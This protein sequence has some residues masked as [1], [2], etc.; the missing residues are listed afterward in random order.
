MDIVSE[1]ILMKL[2]SIFKQESFDI[3]V[4]DD[5]ENKIYKIFIKDIDTTIQTEP[6]VELEFFSNKIYISNINKC[7]ENSGSSLLHLIDNLALSMPNIDYIELNDGSLIE[8]CSTKFFIQLDIFKILTKGISW[9]NSLGYYS[10][11]HEQEV[12]NN[13]IIRTTPINQ[14]LYWCLSYRVNEFLK[15]VSRAELEKSLEKTIAQAK[16]YPD[17]AL[18]NR[19]ILIY[20]Q[21]LQNYD[22]YVEETIGQLKLE[23]DNIIGFG[24]YL[25]PGV[26]MS[27]PT[28][29][30]VN[31]VYSSINKFD[32]TS[33]AN[34]LK[35]RYLRELVLYIKPLITYNINLKKQ[36][37]RRPNIRVGG[38]IKRTKYKRYK[39]LKKN[40]TNKKPK[41]KTKQNKRKENS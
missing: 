18:L 35:Y 27:I 1:D 6:C 40:K 14:L 9:Y 22:K 25:F 32:C 5:D 24:L 3:Q 38:K 28:F 29:E 16:Q 30:Y 4:E 37:I 7:G 10:E 26:D 21:K 33:E 2:K 8:I 31:G 39:K 13:N 20:Q 19:T 15:D 41:Q 11:Q 23:Y 36:I 12:Q 17:D 34:M